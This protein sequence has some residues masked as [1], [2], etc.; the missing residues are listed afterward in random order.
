MQRFIFFVSII[1]WGSIVLDS[2]SAQQPLFENFREHLPAT[3]GLSRDGDI[4]DLNGDGINDLVIGEFVG[5]VRVYLSDPNGVFTEAPFTQPF[6]NDFYSEI[7][8]LDAD[9]DGDQDLVLLRGSASVAIELYTNQGNGQFVAAPGAFPVQPVGV[10]VIRVADIDGDGDDDLYLPSGTNTTGYLFESQGNGTFIDRSS[11]VYSGCG[12]VQDAIF[13]DLDGING[14]DLVRICPA[15]VSAPEIAFNNG[16]GVFL[17]PTLFAPTFLFLL[18]QVAATDVDADGLPDLLF[19]CGQGCSPQGEIAWFR[20]TGGG[21]FAG[22]V[23]LVPPGGVLEFLADDFD[24]DNDPD[25]VLSHNGGFKSYWQNSGGGVYTQVTIPALQ[26]WDEPETMISGDL[27]GDGD[28]DILM[29]FRIAHDVVLLNRGNANFDHV[30]AGYMPITFDY[31]TTTDAA[32]IDNDGDLDLIVNDSQGSVMIWVNDGTGLFT[33][34][35]STRLITSPGGIVGPDVHFADF[36]GDQDQDFLL[37]GATLFGGQPAAIYINNGGVFTNQTATWLPFTPLAQW[38]SVVGDLNGD[39]LPDIVCRDIA[40]GTLMTLINSGSQFNP[41]FS[42]FVPS[43]PQ[44][45]L[46]PD[47]ADLN[48]DGILDLVIYDSSL[49]AGSLLAY[50]GNGSGLFTEIM[51][52]FPGTF[53]GSVTDVLMHDVNGDG[54][55][56]AITAVSPAGLGVQRGGYIWINNGAGTFTDQSATYWPGFSGP[57]NSMRPTTLQVG[58]ADGD[59]IEDLFVGQNPSG[60]PGVRNILFLANAQ[61]Q[62]LGSGIDYETNFLTATTELLVRDFDNDQDIDVFNVLSQQPCRLS[63]GVRR[64]ASFRGLP[65]AG[66]N[67]TLEFHNDPNSIAFLHISLVPPNPV[68]TTLPPWGDWMLGSSSVALGSYPLDANGRFD[69]TFAMNTMPGVSVWWQ[70]IFYESGLLDFRFSN[71]ELTVIR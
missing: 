55:M 31:H 23:Y 45:L 38:P 37:L 9:L 50:Q 66:V 14:P 33:D 57:W 34:E 12:P 1:L 59:G 6:G 2:V 71:L 44:S 32:D 56:D 49:A 28:T 8:H 25:L 18:R 53:N 41:C 69:L 36:D 4:V 70:T 51:N 29:P 40:S 13:A 47:L 24:G 61:G 64:Q 11:N 27:D 42:C 5:T 60:S 21:M 19:L 26:V 17:T 62:F 43:A 46:A 67:T 15:S 48:G 54:A 7:V 16:S 52:A 30:T 35:T 3:G 22:P 68:R 58:D 39:N 63:L 65:S 20:N 10:S